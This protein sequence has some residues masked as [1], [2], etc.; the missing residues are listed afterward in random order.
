MSKGLMGAEMKAPL[1]HLNTILPRWSEG[2][3]GDINWAPVM[4]ESLGQL[5]AV[6]FPV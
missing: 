3:Q 1:K 6:V 4:G 5:I 2:F